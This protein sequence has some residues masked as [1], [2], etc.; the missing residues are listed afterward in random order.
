LL[1]SCACA[2]MGTMVACL[3]VGRCVEHNSFVVW[4]RCVMQFL[5]SAVMQ[6]Q[7]V[8]LNPQQEQ[9]QQWPSLAHQL[10]LG[11]CLLVVTACKQ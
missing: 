7:L 5:P 4:S 1:L 3:L 2:V 9:H 11:H 6:E 10:D 8:L